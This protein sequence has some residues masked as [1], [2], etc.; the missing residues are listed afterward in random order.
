MLRLLFITI[1][2]E[3]QDVNRVI[4]QLCKLLMV[5][6]NDVIII[7]IIIIIIIVVVFYHLQLTKPY[8]N[9]VYIFK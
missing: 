6:Y 3:C 4:M 7:I 2:R 8:N 9:A 5:R 1:F